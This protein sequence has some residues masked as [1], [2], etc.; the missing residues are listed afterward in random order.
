MTARSLL[1]LTAACVLLGTRASAQAPSSLRGVAPWGIIDAVGYGSMGLGLGT[2]FAYAAS[3]EIGPSDA[4]LIAMGASALAGIVGGAYVGQRARARIAGGRQVAEGHRLAVYTGAVL[5]GA[6]VG[7]LASV[8]LINSDNEGT[9]LGS[10]EVTAMVTVGG[11]TMLGVIYAMRHR[12][13]FD[14]GR[15]SVAPY[16]G[17]R[18]GAGMQMRLR[19]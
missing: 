15:V 14:I 6:T 4:G 2:I 17:R 19:F 3:D 7:A 18:G 16:V 5:A 11:G 10:D 1:A 9:P 8:P 12:R 13:D